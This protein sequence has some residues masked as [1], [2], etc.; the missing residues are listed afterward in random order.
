MLR[1]LSYSA[2]LS[3]PIGTSPIVYVWRSSGCLTV[4]AESVIGGPWRLWSL[5]A[6]SH[7]CRGNGPTRGQTGAMDIILGRP[8]R[9]PKIAA[10]PWVGDALVPWKGPVTMDA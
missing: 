10:V 6:P 1:E 8:W 3:S 2:S 4:A 9:W 7:W 5:D